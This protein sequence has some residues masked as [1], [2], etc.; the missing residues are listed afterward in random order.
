M[1]G[2]RRIE[3]FELPAAEGLLCGARPIMF[4][5]PHYRDW[6]NKWAIFIPE[7]NRE[8]VLQSLID[9]FQQEYRPVTLEEIAEARQLF[10]WQSIINGFWRYII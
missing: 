2:L 4:D 9:V 10:D 7:G 5:R 6:F 8:E 3:G 1:S